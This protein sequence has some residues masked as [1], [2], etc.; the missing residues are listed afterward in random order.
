M[1]ADL[2][3]KLT[4]SLTQL[5]ALGIPIGWSAD[6]FETNS[7]GIPLPSG[8]PLKIIGWL[9]TAFAACLGAPF[10]FD[11]LNKLMVVRS[12][13]KP[14]EKSRDERSKD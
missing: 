13:V 6:A 10:W 4:N 11:A 8:W 9:I 12:T 3:C 14:Q 1:S 2:G 5:K 7:R